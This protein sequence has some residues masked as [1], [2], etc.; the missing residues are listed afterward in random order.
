MSKQIE[1][2]GKMFGRLTVVSPAGSSTGKARVALWHCICK[3]GENTISA[4]TKLRNG[5]TVSCG[6]WSSD[7]MALRNYRHGKRRTPEYA[8]W[9]YMQ[10]RCSNPKSIGFKYYGGR[11]I[12]VRYQ[13]FD[14]FLAD[15]G[16]KPSPEMTIDRKDVNGH[17]ERGNCRWATRTEQA[18]NT[19]RT[20]ANR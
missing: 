14:D 19:R 6:C 16:P 13:S 5:K 7:Q 9:W 1:M 17:Y 10:T 8:T 18:N 11:G 12:Q 2:A 4:G 15:V 3:C 20:L